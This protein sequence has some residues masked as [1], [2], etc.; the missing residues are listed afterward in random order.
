MIYTPARSCFLNATV[1]CL[2]HTPAVAQTLGARDGFPL[3]PAKRATQRGAAAQRRRLSLSLSLV[4]RE[5]IRVS[6]RVGSARF[7]PRA[8]SPCVEIW[9]CDSSSLSGRLRANAASVEKRLLFVP[10]ASTAGPAQR[11]ASL[12]FA[13][14][15]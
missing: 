6:R 13:E 3:A 2:A 12:I 15:E 10:S 14:E 11:W 5:M 1:Q 9:C 4:A 7:V 8:L